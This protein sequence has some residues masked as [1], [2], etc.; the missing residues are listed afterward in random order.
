[1]KIIPL[2]SSNAALELPDCVNAVW[3]ETFGIATVN[4][5][6][7]LLLLAAGETAVDIDARVP[8]AVVAAVKVRA[9]EAG[10]AAAVKV[11]AEVAVGGGIKTDGKPDDEAAGPVEG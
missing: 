11:R 1:M 2:S 9:E 7:K 3:L 4:P 5:S 6:P 10:F 8:G